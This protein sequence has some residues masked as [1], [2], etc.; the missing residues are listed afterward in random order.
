M[1]LILLLVFISFRN[2]LIDLSTNVV[3]VITISFVALVSFIAYL[4]FREDKKVSTVDYRR[5]AIAGI[6]IAWTIGYGI[7]NYATYP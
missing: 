7:Y 5:I 4:K 1:I 2:R 3:L 6:F